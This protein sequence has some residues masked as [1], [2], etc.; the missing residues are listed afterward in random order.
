M[1]T[2]RARSHRSASQAPSVRQHSPPAAGRTQL[3]WWAAVLPVPAFAVLLA[4]L[5]GGGEAGAAAQQPTGGAGGAL[6]VS[7][8]ERVAQ[9]L[10]G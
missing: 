6:L 1:T 8:L 5:L 10:L 7:L 9:S 2:A 3:P 4:L